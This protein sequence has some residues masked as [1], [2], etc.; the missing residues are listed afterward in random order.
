MQQQHVLQVHDKLVRLD[1]K[2]NQ[3]V[4][5]KPFP[6]PINFVFQSNISLIFI[7]AADKLLFALSSKHPQ[8]CQLVFRAES[9]ILNLSLAEN[10]RS[11]LLVI[12]KHL[13]D[14]IS[15]ADL[16]L[17][18]TSEVDHPS[19]IKQW[20]DIGYKYSL[21]L[22]SDHITL[23]EYLN[24]EILRVIN[25]KKYLDNIV[26]TKPGLIGY[27]SETGQFIKIRLPEYSASIY[28]KTCPGRSYKKLLFIDTGVLLGL[29]DGML[30]VLDKSGY[31]GIFRDTNFIEDVQNISDKNVLLVTSQSARV[32]TVHDIL[33]T[34]NQLKKQSK[35]LHAT[36]TEPKD[37]LP[38]KAIENEATENVI[39]NKTITSP[40]QRKWLQIETETFPRIDRQYWWS[41]T[42]KIPH[43]QE[44]YLRLQNKGT[45]PIVEQKFKEI[46]MVHSGR[47]KSH[48][49]S[50]LSSLL[51]W[52]EKL[53]ESMHFLPSLVFPFVEVFQF[54]RLSCFE[55]V[56][57][58]IGTL[59]KDLFDFV[60]H[61]YP[62]LHI[63]DFQEYMN[64]CLTNILDR[65]NWFTA[66]DWLILR[67]HKSELYFSLCQHILAGRV[68]GGGSNRGLKINVKELDKLYGMGPI[69]NEKQKL[70]KHYVDRRS[71]TVVTNKDGEFE[72]AKLLDNPKKL[73]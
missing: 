64:C 4:G 19:G 29:H 36:T 54:D 68:I 24:G 6:G 11:T 28:A 3:L 52:D 55:C 20:I 21:A 9:R 58:L 1:P 40:N 71:L 59:F 49:V 51:H 73:N 13:I 48:L 26:F 53:C 62:P 67:G 16:K 69:K 23:I 14:Y 7:V 63:I 38:L 46:Y 50:L 25:S 56:A 70:F 65:E 66:F 39:L 17:F 41:H 72:Y 34:I 45:H 43:H 42:L 5:L 22:M 2:S 18:R 61:S 44:G 33:K 27:S 10:S 60:D 57:T 8:Q 32:L 12:Q 15:V 37:F 47:M 30:D 35:I 31:L